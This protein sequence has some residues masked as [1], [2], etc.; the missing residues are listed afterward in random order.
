VG[1][2]LTERHKHNIIRYLFLKILLYFPTK[3]SYFIHS[4]IDNKL[5]SYAF[6]AVHCV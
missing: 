2:C 6:V 1:S 3:H 4:Q 5:H